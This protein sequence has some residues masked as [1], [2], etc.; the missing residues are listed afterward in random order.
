MQLM[1]LRND[2]VSF[3]PDFLCVGFIVRKSLF[4]W[5]QRWLLVPQRVHF[6]SLSSFSI[7]ISDSPRG[8][9]WLTCLAL[10]I[11]TIILIGQA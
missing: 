10:K 5:K 7:V 3:G 6:T 1:P 2:F 11:I 8:P 4:K 9:D